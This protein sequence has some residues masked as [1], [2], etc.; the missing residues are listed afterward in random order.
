MKFVTLALAVM[1]LAVPATLLFTSN[2]DSLLVDRNAKAPSHATPATSHT[3]R[4]YA[5]R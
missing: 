2:N 3:L 5:A 4:T 1:A